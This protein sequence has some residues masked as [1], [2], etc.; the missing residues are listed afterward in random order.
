[1]G[2]IRDTYHN[3]IKPSENEI[4]LKNI[5]NEAFD[6]PPTQ[7]EETVEEARHCSSRGIPC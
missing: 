7:A 1:M 5:T 3:A 2:R 6:A 4:A